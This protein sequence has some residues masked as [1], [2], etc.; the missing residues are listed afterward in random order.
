M[1][2]PPFRKLGELCYIAGENTSEATKILLILLRLGLRPIY[3]ILGESVCN[4]ISARRAAGEYIREIKI[5]S[6]LGISAIAVKLSKLGLEFNEECARNY[7]FRI[8][9]KAVE[10][11]IKVEIDAERPQILEATYKLICIA[12]QSDLKYF[13]PSILRVAIPANQRCICECRRRGVPCDLNLSYCID[14]FIVQFR[15]FQIPVRVVK[16]AY[17]GDIPEAEIN[18]RF[19]WIIK[20]SYRP[21]AATHDLELILQCFPYVEELQFLFGVRM[22]LQSKLARLLREG[23]LMEWARSK[24]P[25]LFAEIKSSPI[26]RISTYT[27]VGLPGEYLNRRFQEGIRPKVLPLFIINIPG[28]LIW[29]LRYAT[30]SFFSKHRK[31]HRRDSHD[32]KSNRL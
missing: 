6:E 25:D 11:G 12:A 24:R 21:A 13:L 29:R 28:A 2:L 15:M 16:G 4:R 26:K 10:L 5:K 22:W 1:R 27:P 18:S 8:I 3:D 19:L 14:R 31:T 30:F 9:H 17:P 7:L 23:K 32:Y 20:H